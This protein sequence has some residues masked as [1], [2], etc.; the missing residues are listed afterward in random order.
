LAVHALKLPE[1][2]PGNSSGKRKRG[3]IVGGV[4]RSVEP[5]PRQFPCGTRHEEWQAAF[6]FS[7]DTQAAA[8]KLARHYWWLIPPAPIPANGHLLSRP[9]Y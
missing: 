5:F 3:R 9:S 4:G 1:N 6:H 7:P 8:V 2:Y